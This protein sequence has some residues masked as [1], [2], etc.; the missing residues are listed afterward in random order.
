[1]HCANCAFI[2]KPRLA[3]HFKFRFLFNHQQIS[4]SCSLLTSTFV[5][6]VTFTFTFTSSSHSCSMLKKYHVF[7]HSSHQLSC[8]R[9]R[10]YSRSGPPD[11]HTVSRLAGNFHVYTYG[12]KWVWLG[13]TSCKH[14]GQAQCAM[15]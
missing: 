6:T 5:F 12:N 8:S 11:T 1:M 10:S 14:D 9:S 7:V 15:I 4:H 2:R 3:I 13:K